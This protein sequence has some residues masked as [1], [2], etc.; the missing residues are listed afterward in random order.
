MR[1][2]VRRC[3][4]LALAGCLL[5]ALP[6]TAAEGVTR[7]LVDVQWL[8]QHL[9]DP[10][11]LILDASLGPAYTAQHIPG[12]VSVDAFVYGG[13]E[14]P[15]AD[16][17]RLYQSW[18]VSPG[19]TVVLYDQGGSFMATRLFFSLY[20][21]GFPAKN[22][23]IL[24]GGLSKWQEAGLPVTKDVTP[25]PKKGSF[26]IA[27]SNEEVRA[28][29]ADV[30]TASGDPARHALLEALGADWH[31][32]EVL[33]FNRAGHIPNGVLL[34]SADLYNADKTFKSPEELRRI[35]KYL[36][37]RPDQQIHTYCGGGVAASAPFF[38]LKF[39]LDYPHVKL[40]PESE[41]GWLSDERQLP[42]WT[43]DAPNLMRDTPWLQW[44]G[45]Q[46]ARMYVGASVSVVDMYGPQRHSIRGTCHLRSTCLRTCF[47]AILATPRRWRRRWAQPASTRRSRRWWCQA[48]G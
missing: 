9:H 13:K 48:P 23:A 39:L 32:G 8:E 27:T 7:N 40:Y 11:V 41:M 45:G 5:V 20:Y 34:P 37:I 42:Y 36:N 14:L 6:A 47:A 24:D 3:P 22:L 43:Y 26:T 30:L 44:S 29:L 1:I 33:A 12:A 4:F 10:D 15:L 2:D 38:A 31:F 35:L 18:G 16:A 17:E 28:R 25:A 21:H 19:M 46:R